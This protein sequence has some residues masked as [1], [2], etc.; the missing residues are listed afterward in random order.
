VN[1]DDGEIIGNIANCVAIAEL[2]VWL[3]VVWADPIKWA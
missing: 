2:N 1:P 3:S